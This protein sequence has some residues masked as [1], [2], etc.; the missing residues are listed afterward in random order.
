MKSGN[1][2]FLLCLLFSNFSFNAA[3]ITGKL[4]LRKIAPWMIDPRIIASRI[5]ASE[6]NCLR[7]KV[8]PEFLLTGQLPPRK[9][10]SR[11]IAP[12]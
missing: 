1:A 7:G 2:A 9:I 8:L 4:P 12:G 6:D 3:F 10:S 5:I 11:I